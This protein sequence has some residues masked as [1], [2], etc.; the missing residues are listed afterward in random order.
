MHIY[1]PVSQYPLRAIVSAC[2]VKGRITDCVYCG[3]AK[4]L[5]IYRV[6]DIRTGFI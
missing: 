4:S 3:A 5:Y 2:R 1:A 6:L